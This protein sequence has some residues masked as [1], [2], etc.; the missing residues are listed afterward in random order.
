M[1]VSS[2]VQCVP[3][4]RSMSKQ[5]WRPRKDPRRLLRGPPHRAMGSLIPPDHPAAPNIFL[6]I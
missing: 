4:H 2:T 6:K 3:P 1:K 5:K